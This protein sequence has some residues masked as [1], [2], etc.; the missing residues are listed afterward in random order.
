MPAFQYHAI[1]QAG[2]KHKGVL[3]GDS[4]RQIR[5]LLRERGLVPIEVKKVDNK[6]SAKKNFSLSRKKSISVKDLALL[7]RQLSTLLSSG[8]PLEEALLAVA[9]QSEKTKTK[10]ILLAVRARVLEGHTLATGLREFPAAFSSLYCATVAAGE[11]S[12]NLSIILTRLAD[13][14]EKQ[15]KMRQKLK[16]A[17]IYPSIM[18]LVSIAIVTFLLIYV[19]PKMIAVFHTTGQSLPTATTILIA[20]SQFIKQYGIYTLILIAIGGFCFKRALY[21]INFKT[22]VHRAILKLPLIGNATKVINTARFSRT[23][24][25]LIS[26]S[27]PVLDAMKVSSQLIT[28]LPMRTAV[29]ATIDK[30]REGVNIHHA[31]KQTSYFPAMSIHLI[32]SGE[33]SGQ[34]ESMLER[35]ADNQDLSIEQL[36]DTSLTLFEPLMILVMGSVVLFIVLAIMLPIFS[37][38]NFG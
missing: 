17:M 1:N 7:T 35:A 2:T 30:V 24:S 26:A 13:Y 31:L 28:N 38:D 12:G 23:L 18:T 21:N 9:E 22:A 34:L 15:Q 8:L 37:M 16:Q 20:I 25:I 4:E 27:T 32:A 11:Q 10:S 33:A 14:T 3:E 36:I 29:E 5:Q 19:V 6:I